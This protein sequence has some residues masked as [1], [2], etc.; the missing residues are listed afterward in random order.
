MIR[1]LVL[2]VAV[3]LLAPLAAAESAADQQPLLLDGGACVVLNP[4][5]QS[6]AVPPAINP[7]VEG[8]TPEPL[9]MNHCNAAQ[10][11]SDGSQVSCQGHQS[12]TVQSTSVTCDGVTHECPSCSGVKSGCLDPYGFCYCRASGGTIVYCTSE[13]C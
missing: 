10:N 1:S 9:W 5:G 8:A 4:A 2:V 3:L 11:C 12:C 13:F 7:E 6:A